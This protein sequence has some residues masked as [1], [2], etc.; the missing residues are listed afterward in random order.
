MRRFSASVGA[1]ILGFALLVA[2]AGAGNAT[3][4][5]KFPPKTF[6]FFRTHVDITIGIAGNAPPPTVVVFDTKSGKV[7]ATAQ[8][9]GWAVSGR[10]YRY[11]ATISG[12]G[13]FDLRV[14]GTKSQM[15]PN[16]CYSIGWGGNGKG[17]VTVNASTPRTIQ[18]S[19]NE[20]TLH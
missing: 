1:L 4:T 10:S 12:P 5:L 16:C 13:V 11:V 7:A 8:Y 19:S 6:Q 20:Q 14:T 3:P 18:M 17:P 2:S 15:S 9:Y